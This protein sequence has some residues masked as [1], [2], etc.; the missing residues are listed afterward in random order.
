MT[1]R[2]WVVL[3]LSGKGE[4]EAREGTLSY[5]LSAKSKFERADIF[6]PYLRIGSSAPICLMEGYVFIRTGYP[7]NEYWGLK[8]SGLIRSV[9]SELDRESGLISKGTVTDLDLKRMISKADALGGKYKEGDRVNIKTGP[10]EGLEGEVINVEKPANQ[11]ERESAS[12][13]LDCDKNSIKGMLSVYSILIELRSAE[14][15]I[16]LDCFSIEGV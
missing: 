8:E 1:N 5:S 15:V 14:V 6:V 3:E 9:L 11:I 16:T 2:P 12:F 7:S 4:K 10:F 13:D